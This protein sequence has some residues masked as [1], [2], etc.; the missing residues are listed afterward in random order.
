MTKIS[1]IFAASMSVLNSDLSLNV[2]KTIDH[3]E[4]LID[5]RCVIFRLLIQKCGNT[6]TCGSLRKGL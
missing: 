2:D 3:A 6:C 5:Q 4:M 1:G